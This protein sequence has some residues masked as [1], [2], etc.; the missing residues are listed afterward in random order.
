MASSM[1]GGLLAKGLPAENISA[2]DPK[3]ESLQKLLQLGPVSTSTDNFA[4]V[5]DVDVVV[6]AVKP[7][8]MRD[9]VSPLQSALQSNGAVVVS[10]AAGIT[11]AQFHRWLGDV[12]II[13]C[14]P[15]TPA[16][17]RAGASALFAGNGVSPAQCQLAEAVLEAV[18]TVCWTDDEA[19]MDAV[20]ALSGSGP[21]YFFLLME[22][23]SAAGA[24]LGLNAATSEALAIQTAL[25]AARMAAESDLSIDE[26]RRRVTSPN[27]TTERAV[28]SLQA[29]GL[30]HIV[31]AAMA[32]A[33]HR[34]RELAEET[35]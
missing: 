12:P 18:G 2:S 14:M 4:T 27:G 16:L 34:S 30:E 19:Q 8:L 6:L 10:I 22:A 21:A 7:Q 29:S 26:L 23:M 28:N 17:L 24:K 5:A 9:V 33:A 13:R 3:P 32:A 20:T 1:V 25:G 11:L 31:E 15:N 35:E